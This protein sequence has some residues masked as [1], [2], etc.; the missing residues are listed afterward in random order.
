MHPSPSIHEIDG[1][2]T[3]YSW[4]QI[5]PR[6]LKLNLYRLHLMVQMKNMFARKPKFHHFCQKSFNLRCINH[7]R[8]TAKHLY[9]VVDTACS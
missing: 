4:K 6:T 1:R 8:N 2:L 7:Q 3:E 5:E 9:Q